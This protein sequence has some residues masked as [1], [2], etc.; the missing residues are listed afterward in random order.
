[1]IPQLAGRLAVVT[2]AGA[3]IGYATVQ[4][5]TAA[6]DHHIRTVRGV[7]LGTPAEATDI[8]NAIVFL[9]SDAA[10][11]ITGTVLPVH[12]GMATHLM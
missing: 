9:A 10:S 3:G 1:M 5:L 4:Q 7:A 6:G 8:A 12:G 11:H 2:G